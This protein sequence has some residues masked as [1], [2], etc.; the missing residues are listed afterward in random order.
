MPNIAKKKK[1]QGFAKTQILLSDEHGHLMGLVRRGY[2][3]AGI[4]G[5]LALVYLVR[6]LDNTDH[7]S[8]NLGVALLLLA[9]LWGVGSSILQ[10]VL[11]HMRG[12]WKQNERM[13]DCIEYLDGNTR[14]IG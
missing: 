2:G 5:L 6:G 9:L 10:K 7:A 11:T 12:L 8:F 13:M 1:V 4:H 14:A 3:T